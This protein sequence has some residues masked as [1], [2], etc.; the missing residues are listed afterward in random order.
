M[1][2]A[3]HGTAFNPKGLESNPALGPAIGSVAEFLGRAQPSVLL[4][5]T[6]LNPETGEIAIS[7]IPS[8]FTRKIHVITANKGPIAHA[9]AELRQEAQLGRRRISLRIYRAGWNTRFNLFRHD[10]PALKVL[11]FTGVLHSTSKVVVVA[12]ARGVTFDADV[13]KHK[14]WHGF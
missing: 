5:I 6:T 3:R 10:F 8:A 13:K 4:E 7:H 12:M 9:F 1:H 14:L 2:T 11:G